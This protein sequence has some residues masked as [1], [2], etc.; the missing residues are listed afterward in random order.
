MRQRFSTL[1]PGGFA[2]WISAFIDWLLLLPV[3]LLLQ[4]YLQPSGAAVRWIWLLPLLVAGGVLLRRICSRL[5][6]Q[7][8]AAL[9]LGALAVSI[10]GPLALAGIPLMAGA[11][12]SAY[13]GMTAAGR[14]NR[15]KMYIAGLILYFI[16]AIIY[17]RIPELQPN[18]AA[19][20]WS[21]SLC[22]VL[23][24]LDSNSSHLRYSS[25]NGD[26]ARLPQGLRGHNRLF[27]AGFIVAA[28]LLAAGGGKAAGTL[29][30][31][32][33][34]GFFIWLTAVLSGSEAPAPVT[35]ELPAAN[36]GFPPVESGEPGLLSAI[37]NILFYIAGTA[38]LLVILYYI[39]RWLYSNTGGILRRAID[40]L[41]TLLRR[42]SPSA[43]A[44]YRDEETSLFTWEQTVQGFR[45]YLRSKLSPASRKD[46]W[47][48]MNGSRERVRWLYRH[49]LRAKQAE[50][51]ELKTYLTPQETA[52]D[53]AEWSEGQKRQRSGSG[54]RS[55][56]K[57][58]GLYNR[59]R[60]GG[61]ELPEPSAEEVAALK[62]QLKL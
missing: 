11:A 60:Y 44:G 25:M 5:W 6:N 46:R 49:W 39:L 34:R 14:Q 52:A 3:W 23:A 51:Y 55:A 41:L 40:W 62:E 61:E 16:S 47:E 1:L 58:P 19:L 7:L 48:G 10:S 20:T 38:L 8:L 21:G 53:V 4:S 56:D 36:S 59:A 37:L 35:E 31:R 42:E 2:L 54:G 17:S 22:L 29:L 33:V 32:A 18:V 9:L 24:L 43:A 15:L 26:T 57:L 27:V 45:D 50:G 28:A 13:L 12:V 30:W